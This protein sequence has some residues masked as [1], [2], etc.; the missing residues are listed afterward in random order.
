M[1]ITPST[2]LWLRIRASVSSTSDALL[3]VAAAMVVV[4]VVAPLFVLICIGLLGRLR[5]AAAFALWPFPFFA[6]VTCQPERPRK[7]LICDTSA[8]H[9]K[10]QKA[11]Y[12]RLAAG[13]L[14]PARCCCGQAVHLSIGLPTARMGD[15]GPDRSSVEVK[16][17][18]RKLDP[19]TGSSHK[20]R[21]RLLNRFRNYAEGGGG[22]KGDVSAVLYSFV[23]LLHFVYRP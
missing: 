9:G 16:A 5:L 13:L 22:G 12:Q 17:L 20:D 21:V 10:K 3:V 11:Q 6:C 18:L 1:M 7:L 8:G 14:L 15:A 23:W 19:K 2:P 4:V